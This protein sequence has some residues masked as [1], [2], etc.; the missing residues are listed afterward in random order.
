[1]VCL[2]R[3]QTDDTQKASLRFALASNSYQTLID[4][5]QSI[6][7]DTY[8]EYSA[9]LTAPEHS[10]YAVVSFQSDG[11]A[12]IDGCSVVQLPQDQ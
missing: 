12:S 7:S 9:T 11:S 2:A 3:N 5:N 10:I 1:M 6:S 8:E 4:E